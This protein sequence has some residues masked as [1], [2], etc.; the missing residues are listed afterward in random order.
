MGDIGEDESVEKLI[1]LIARTHKKLDV[2][3]NN[4]G[5]GADRNEE[6]LI[7]V[8]DDIHRVNLRNVYYLCLKF[9]S[10]RY[11]DFKGIH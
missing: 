7:K 4:A 3:V 6:S 1:D 10:N 8:F 2:L 5:M 9:V 11:F